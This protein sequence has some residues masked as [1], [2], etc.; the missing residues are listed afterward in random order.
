MY[1]VYKEGLK[2]PELDLMQKTNE[3]ISSHLNTRHGNIRAIRIKDSIRQ[4]GVSSNL[5]FALLI[6]E[7]NKEITKKLGTYVSNLDDKIG[8]LLCAPN[9][10][11]AKQTTA[12][13]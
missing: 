12:Y 2:G 11:Q 10:I 6:D 9:I 3:N 7:I 1:V 8:C 5:Q 4:E 13:A